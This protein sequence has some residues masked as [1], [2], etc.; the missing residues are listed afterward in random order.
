MIAILNSSTSSLQIHLFDVDIEN[1]PKLMESSSTM[2]G[3]KIVP[4]IRTP[5]GEIGLAVC[6]DLRF[7]AFTVK[8]GLGHWEVLLRARAIET[9]CYVVAA[10][11]VGKH[12]AK[13]ESYGHSLIIDPWGT[14]V[15]QSSDSDMCLAYAE[16]D[17]DLIERIRKEMPVQNHRRFLVIG[18]EREAFLCAVNKTPTGNSVKTA[19][20]TWAV[21]LHH[22][23]PDDQ[24]HPLR[25]SI[26]FT[27]AEADEFATNFGFVNLGAVWDSEGYYSMEVEVVE[28]QD[29]VVDVEGHSPKLRKRTKVSVEDDLL[30]SNHVR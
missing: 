18:T 6:Y 22:E 19:K 26:P 15:A 9:Q 4:P 20:H 2:R 10:A 5:V 7:P 29:E 23:R 14:I 17:S 24:G 28:P 25:K 12:N 11:A 21:Q 13:R 3:A 1:G 16:I 30:Q 8:T 27:T